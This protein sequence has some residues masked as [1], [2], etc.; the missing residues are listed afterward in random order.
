MS[1]LYDICEAFFGKA[2]ISYDEW[3]GLVEKY[4]QDE[5]ERE[6]RLGL[7]ERI[8]IKQMRKRALYRMRKKLWKCGRGKE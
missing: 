6:F 3:L 8:K 7:R 5:A 1:K 4:L 2:K